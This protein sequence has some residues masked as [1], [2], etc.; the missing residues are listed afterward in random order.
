[1]SGVKRLVQEDNKGLAEPTNE[2][3]REEGL[4]GADTDS[5]SDE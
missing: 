1:M 3:I 5:D 4:A 2:Q